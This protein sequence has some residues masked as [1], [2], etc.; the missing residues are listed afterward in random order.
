MPTSEVARYRHGFSEVYLAIGETSEDDRVDLRAY[1]K[2]YVL[3]I[4]LGPLL[5]SLAGMLSLFD[6]RMRVGAPARARMPPQGA[7][8]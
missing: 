1:A 6:R 2:P 8:A 5:M 7:R 4:W 3:L